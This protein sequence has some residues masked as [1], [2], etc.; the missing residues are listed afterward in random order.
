M[1]RQ[2]RIVSNGNVQHMKLA[3]VLNLIFEWHLK[4]RV[5]IFSWLRVKLGSCILS[6][7]LILPQLLGLDEFS[8]FLVQKFCWLECLCT[9]ASVVLCW[10]FDSD[11]QMQFHALHLRVTN[12]AATSFHFWRTFFFSLWQMVRYLFKAIAMIRRKGQRKGRWQ[13]SPGWVKRGHVE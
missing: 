2:F 1:R 13:Q 3:A 10:R 6:L 11:T 4:L 12:L 9:S 7:R 5:I 8:L